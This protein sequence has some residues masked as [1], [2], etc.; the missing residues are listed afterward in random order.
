MTA[1]L[2]LGASPGHPAV[3]VAGVHEVLDALGSVSGVG[4][5]SYALLV[6]ECARARSRL[7]A[8]ELSLVA[9]ADRDQVPQAAGARSAGAWLAGVTR[10]DQA[11]S[12]RDARLAGDLDGG[13]AATA[14]ALGAGEVST[15]HARVIAHACRR[16]PKDLDADQRGLVESRLVRAARVCDP[17]ELR[18]RARRALAAVEPDPVVVEVHEN[19]VVVDE[20]ARAWRRARLSLHD[21]A[22]G[23]TT[24]HFTVPSLAASVLR[25]VIRAMT[26]PRRGRVGA[27][28]AQADDQRLDRDH[29]H[30]CGVAFA[31]VLERLPS[32]GLSDKVAATVVVKVDLDTLVGRLKVAGLDTG[33]VISAGEARRIA[34]G[35]GIVPAVLGGESLPLDVGRARRFF[36]ATQ[37]TAAALVHDSC[38]A[39]GCDIPFAWCDMHHRQPWSQGGRT[40]LADLVPVCGFH[41]HRIHDPAFRHRHR[42]DG[43]VI[44]HRRT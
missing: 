39:E 11:V 5:E 24:G 14:A 7:R 17:R 37:R 36:T 32:D 8:L 41:H 16:L 34:C 42:G 25:T 35:A 23:T 12:A 26:S 9:A 43:A 38:A 28:Q 21:N 33:E 31:Q 27:S 20:E 4:R 15:E 1:A 19:A 3:V 6:A 40:D 30:E 44:F 29:A 10:A 18:R 13:L 22:D 2:D